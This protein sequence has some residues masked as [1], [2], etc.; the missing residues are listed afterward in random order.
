MSLSNMLLEGQISEMTSYFSTEYLI[1]FLPAVALIFAIFPQK[2]RKYV[3]LIASYVFVWLI[4]GKLVM[5]L[6]LSSLSVHYFG[7]WLSRIA[8][9]RDE[10]VKLAERAD[11]KAIKAQFK[12]QQRNVVILAAVLHFGALVVLKYSPFFLGNI[13]SVIHLFNPNFELVI[14]KMMVPIGISFFTMQAM[15]YIFDVYRGVVKADENLGRLALFVSFFPQIVEGPICRYNETAEQLWN[16]KQ[17]NF[18]N[19][20]LGVQRIM[21]GLMKK[22]VVADRINLPVKTIFSNYSEYSGGV[23]ALGAVLYTIQLYMDFSGTMD[24]VIGTAQIFGINM[25]ENFKRPFFSKT[26][27]EFWK[28]WHISLGAWFRD[29]IFYPVT[30][31]KPMKNLTSSARKKLGNHFGPLL[32]GSVALFAVW[33]CNGLWHGSGWQYIFFGMYHFVLILLGSIIEPFV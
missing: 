33:Y 31:S 2:C 15:S 24:A 14:P 4:S 18:N 11:R 12:T 13:N 21:F 30:M 9:K 26:I 6:V 25:P 29:Y 28:R 17:I 5:Y 10:A 3:L 1:M 23:L 32:A 19:L 8:Q 22:I 27:S 7:L 16:V 20:T